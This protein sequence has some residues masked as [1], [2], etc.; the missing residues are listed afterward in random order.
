MK[1]EIEGKAEKVNQLRK[2]LK[3]RCKNHNI[4][5]KVVEDEPEAKPKRKRKSKK[6]EDK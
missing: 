6:V 5:L 1:L 3:L 4:V 2:E